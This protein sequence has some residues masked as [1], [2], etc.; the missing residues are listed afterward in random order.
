MVLAQFLGRGRTERLCSTSP[1]AASAASHTEASDP[2]QNGGVYDRDA[3]LRQQVA[4][5]TITQFVNDMPSY[6][7]NDQEVI[8]MTAF[9]EFWLQGRD[10]TAPR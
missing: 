10:L 7:L 8:E 2:S 5:V 3:A 1:Y 9:E 6:G 4:H